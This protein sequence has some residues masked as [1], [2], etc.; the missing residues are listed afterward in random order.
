MVGIMIVYVPS[1][2]MFALTILC[3]EISKSRNGRV[4]GPWERGVNLDSVDYIFGIYP[5]I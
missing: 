5:G 2:K 1:F 4:A 3:T